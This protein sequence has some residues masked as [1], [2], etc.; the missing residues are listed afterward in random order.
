[1]FNITTSTQ[2]KNDANVGEYSVSPFNCSANP[3]EIIDPPEY[4]SN[5]TSALQVRK[6]NGEMQNLDRG[7]IKAVIAWATQGIDIDANEL[8]PFIE[9]SFKNG[10]ETVTIQ[11]NLIYY[12]TTKISL[13]HPEWGLVAGRLLLSELRKNVGLTRGTN[14]LRPY[15]D[16]YAYIQEQ[17]RIGT[18]HPGLQIYKE[19]ELKQAA[20]L[21]NPSY[22]L[23][24]DYA[25][26]YSLVNRYLFPNEQPQELF[27]VNALMLA[28]KELP[29]QRMDLVAKYYELLAQ[30]KISLAT[31]LMKNLRRP[32]GSLT[33]CFISMMDDNLDSIYA[34]MTRLARISKNGGGAGLNLSHIR[35]MGAPVANQPNASGGI[36]PWLKLVNDTGVAV[37]QAGMR[38]G[39]ITAALDVWHIDIGDLL[40][41]QTENGDQRRKTHDIFPQIV[42]N[43]VFMNRVK[44]AQ[45]W[46]CVDPYEIKQVLGIDL[47]PLW[48]DKFAEAYGL[49]ERAIADGILQDYSYKKINARELFITVLEAEI[50]SGM[51]YIAFKDAIN[52]ANPNKH[53]GYIPSVNLCVESFSNVSFEEDHCCN[54]SSLN[55]V[56]LVEA[57]PAELEEV[58]Y[59]CIRLLD[60]S[61]DLT[62]PPNPEATT[63]NNKYRT[64]GLGVMGLADWL[65]Y[66]HKR[67]QDLDVIENLFEDIALYSVEASARLAQEK[68]AFSTFK[69]SEWNRG[70]LINSRTLA[71]IIADCQAKNI[72]RWQAVAELIAIYGIRNSQLISIAP[73][74]SSGLVQ[75]ATPSILPAF[76][77][78]RT[79][80]NELGNVALVV[81]FAKEHFWFYQENKY[82]DQN[83]VVDAVSRMQKWV[84]TGISMEL[85]FNLNLGVYDSDPN[86]QITAM[87]I[88][89]IHLKA[90][91]QG[92]KTIYYTRCIDLDTPDGTEKRECSACA[93]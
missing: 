43:D 73:N 56:N 37:N 25:T 30:R 47:C 65:A 10:I 14:P 71:D 38:A 83:V 77:R 3:S 55:L 78:L 57:T 31:P 70:K 48:G 60:A 89:F 79:F 28:S 59:Y 51:P 18:C 26:L 74:T 17:I 33:S 39:A 2:N 75:S 93:D 20:E 41:S 66:H 64:V 36:M 88:F 67:Y 21:I 69:Q 46:Y 16:F 52:R 92:C 4:L 87:D 32:Q 84:D 22:D 49:V 42:V 34:V 19:A 29:E 68:G 58:C 81:P 23:D 90:W 63:H 15:R 24:Y 5:S 82:L 9:Q 53:L 45:D 7:K 61:I 1:M 62:T 44:Y 86:H 72:S 40:D 91:E 85:L 76:S 12:A 50:E 13:E 11:R 8:N 27:M 80:K 6:R 54:L 35:G